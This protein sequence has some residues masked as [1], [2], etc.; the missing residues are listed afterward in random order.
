M[1]VR[2]PVRTAASAVALVGAV[3]GPVC[4]LAF[5]GPGS[6]TAADLKG[7]WVI[8]PGL[9]FLASPFLA[10]LLAARLSTTRAGAALVLALALAALLFGGLVYGDAVRRKN[11]LLLLLFVGVPMVQWLMA[12]PALVAALVL[13]RRKPPVTTAR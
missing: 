8:L 1:A 7:A 4:L 3:L 9:A 2:Q 13:R 12:L 5:P 10:F 6:W 11:F